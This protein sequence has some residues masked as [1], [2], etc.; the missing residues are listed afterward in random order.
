MP[1]KKAQVKATGQVVEVCLIESVDRH[2]FI[3]HHWYDP[4]GKTKYRDDELTFI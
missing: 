3:S 4:N 1:P 2:G